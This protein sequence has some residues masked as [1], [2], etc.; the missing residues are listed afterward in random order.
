MQKVAFLFH[1]LLV[2]ASGGSEFHKTSL[3]VLFWSF[4]LGA[5]PQEGPK[6]GFLSPRWEWGGVRDEIL[7][8]TL[9]LCRNTFPTPTLY[10]RGG[11]PWSFD[12]LRASATRIS[13]PGCLGNSGSSSPQSSKG[14]GSPSPL[15][16]PPL[17]CPDLRADNVAVVLAPSAGE[18]WEWP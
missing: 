18:C 8:R 5:A 12:D 7:H 4:S 16:G 10:S 6:M 11:G 14:P 15:I 3:S 2:L 1:P 13:E 17:P 9:S